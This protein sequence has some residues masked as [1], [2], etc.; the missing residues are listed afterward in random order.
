MTTPFEFSNKNRML[1]VYNYLADTGE[2]IGEADALIPAYTGLPAFCTLIAP[3]QLQKGRVAIFT[4]NNWSLMEDHRGTVVYNT[5]TGESQTI[6]QPGS[7]PENTTLLA[8]ASPFDRWDGK[9][10]VKDDQEEEQ[11]YLTE[12]QQKK[13]TLLNQA[14]TQI[15]ILND[16]IELN[17][18]TTTTQ[19]ELLAWRKYRIQLDQLDISTAPDID[20]PVTPL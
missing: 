19:S 10:W 8:P 4:G 20:W 6:N 7:L 1:R 15:D 17:M 13:K 3:P 5:Q 16:S 12:A 9:Q 14:N 11:Y 2:F 18:A